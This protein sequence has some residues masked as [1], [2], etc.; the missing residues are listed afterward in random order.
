MSHT[1]SSLVWILMALTTGVKVGQS[2]CPAEGCLREAQTQSLFDRS[3]ATFPATPTAIPDTIPA[4]SS[5]R[6]ADSNTS[7]TEI[8]E[9]FSL[10]ATTALPAGVDG[11]G[12]ITRCEVPD[13]VR[14][15]GFKRVTNSGRGYSHL[16]GRPMPDACGMFFGREQN[17]E[18]CTCSCA[19]DYEGSCE[20]DCHS[21]AVWQDP[22]RLGHDDRTLVYPWALCFCDAVLKANDCLKTSSEPVDANQS[23]PAVPQ[24]VQQAVG[25]EVARQ[26]PV[27]NARAGQGWGLGWRRP[28]AQ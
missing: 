13:D 20:C 4:T 25:D 14:D 19:E 27:K 6:G 18:K 21:R 24:G 23:T 1:A 26:P 12:T 8:A 22:Q 17:C 5:S 16:P 3:D 15:N 10:N 9:M 7:M 11:K 28:R 2:T